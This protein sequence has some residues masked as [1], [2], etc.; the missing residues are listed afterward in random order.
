MKSDFDWPVVS[1]EMF[2]E[3]EWSTTEAYLS[4]KLTKWAFD[5]GELKMYVGDKQEIGQKGVLMIYS[6][7]GTG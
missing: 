3:C 6:C 4:H 1:E 7:K 2:K 5:P